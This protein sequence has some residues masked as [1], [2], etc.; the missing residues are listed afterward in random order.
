MIRLLVI[1]AKS[2]TNNYECT[3]YEL[4][5]HAISHILLQ[6]QPNIERKNQYMKDDA[7]LE[8]QIEQTSELHIVNQ[9]NSESV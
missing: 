3:N 9:S 5:Y 8:K 1:I 2:I 7:K 6:S 4:F